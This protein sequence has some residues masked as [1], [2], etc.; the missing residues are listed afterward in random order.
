MPN[1][2]TRRAFAP[3]K[4]NL[5]LRII[6]RRPD[7]YHLLDSLMLPISLYDEI[8]FEVSLGGPREVLF[9]CDRAD[10]PSGGANLAYRAADLILQH[11]QVEARVS[12]DLRKRIPAGSGLGG[13][14]SDA[15][16]TLLTLNDL[17]NLGHG[18]DELAGWALALGADVP[19]FIYGT[20]AHVSG[21][22][23]VVTPVEGWRGI[24]LV[25]AFP[26][27]GLATAAVYQRYDAARGGA[28]TSLTNP[29]SATSIAA[30]AGSE[31]PLRELLVNDLEAVAAE[32]HPELL[33]LKNLL[34]QLGAD[35]ALMTGSGSAVFGIWP[36]RAA[37]ETA[38]SA[39]RGRGFWA[40]AVETL[41]GAAAPA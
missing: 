19:F 20:A 36:T 6:G 25:V 11:A 9:A 16:T 34:V 35:G 5:F 1:P 39:V 15:A 28:R 17:L 14:S 29:G 26:G 38:A 37:A 18:R 2:L 27:T 33:S 21:I 13:G 4:I 7:G 10:I 30:L 24:P 32:V 23:E 31:K 8:G 3:A 40:E 41:G 12:L 22:G